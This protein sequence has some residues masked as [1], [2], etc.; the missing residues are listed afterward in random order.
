MRQRLLLDGIDAETRRAPVGRQDQPVA[1]ARAD[2]A[3]T[4]LPVGQ[5]TLARAQVA[6][7]PA[8]VS[9]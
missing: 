7:Q 5:V 9:P 6:L 4:S 2:E 3:E 8:V 1:V